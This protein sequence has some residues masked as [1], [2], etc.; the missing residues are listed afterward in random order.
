MSAVALSH[1]SDEA[2]FYDSE[3]GRN[4]KK[5]SC[6]S[7]LETVEIH[8]RETPGVDFGRTEQPSNK[9]EACAQVIAIRLRRHLD[10]AIV[11][12]LLAHVVEQV[13]LPPACLNR[14]ALV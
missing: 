2:D 9:D 14:F 4:L 8:F 3:R 11:P 1:I 5:W 10:N 6:T 12:V 7:D 13:S